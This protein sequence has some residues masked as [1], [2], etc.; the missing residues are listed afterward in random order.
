MIMFFQSLKC[1]NKTTSDVAFVGSSSLIVTGGHSSESR[2]VC[3]W[4]TLLPQR[5]SCVHGK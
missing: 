5:S 4:D 2:N 3:L 1:H